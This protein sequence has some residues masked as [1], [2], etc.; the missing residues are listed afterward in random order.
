[1]ILLGEQCD[2]SQCSHNDGLPSLTESIQPAEVSLAHSEVRQLAEQ[3]AGLRSDQQKGI[4]EVKR[5]QQKGMAEVKHDQ[6]KFMAEVKRGNQ[7]LSEIQDHVD[8]VAADVRTVKYIAGQTQ[9]LIY[10]QTAAHDGDGSQSLLTT[11][12]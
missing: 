8:D 11:A 1:M 5:D 7:K 3:V 12:L 10:D 6:Q 9:S 4:A 2:S